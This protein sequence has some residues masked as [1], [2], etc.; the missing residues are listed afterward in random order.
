M[1]E[2]PKQTEEIKSGILKFL[3]VDSLDIG[4]QLEI[5]QYYDGW[6]NI[7]LDIS[8]RN[9]LTDVGT[10]NFPRLDD[11]NIE[12]QEWFTFAGFFRPG[13]H[14]VLIYDP[15]YERAFC[16]D[17]IVKQNMR[18][19]IYPEYPIPLVKVAAK[20]VPD[21]WRTWIEDSSQDL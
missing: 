2:T 9:E 6:Q 17:I 21:M 11:Y 4:E 20:V 19:F 1:V 10:V 8:Q 13:Y 7:I 14:Q 18:D 15:K 5:N 3:K 16:K 12:R